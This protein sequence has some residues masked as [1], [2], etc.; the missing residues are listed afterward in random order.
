M[1]NG[2]SSNLYSAMFGTLPLF[3][4]LGPSRAPLSSV[5]PLYPNKVKFVLDPY[6]V[7]AIPSGMYFVVPDLSINEKMLLEKAI[8]C[9]AYSS[10]KHTP[11]AVPDYLAR[12]FEKTAKGFPYFNEL[13]YRYGKLV[14]S[15][16]TRCLITRSD[17]PVDLMETNDHSIAATVDYV[18]ALCQGLISVARHRDSMDVERLKEDIRFIRT[19]LRLTTKPTVGFRDSDVI[20][21]V[22]DHIVYTTEDSEFL[23]DLCSLLY[24]LYDPYTEVTTHMVWEGNTVNTP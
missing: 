22:N 23:S 19:K 3:S 5:S 16:P 8:L 9:T 13:V 4:C 20:T 21:I 14:Y 2:V 11:L 6:P 15:E 18:A 10:I 7:Q 1:Q 17:S 24:N 12:K